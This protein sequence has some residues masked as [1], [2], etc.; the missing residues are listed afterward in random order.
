M[1]LKENFKDYLEKNK[2]KVLIGMVFIMV[3]GIGKIFLEKKYK[4]NLETES[5]EAESLVKDKNFIPDAGVGVNLLEFMAMY[6]ELQNTNPNDTL[7]VKKI[8]NKLDKM[9]NNEKN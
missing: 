4:S 3:A 7:A 8:D 6:S 9:M 2:V 1:K 5:L